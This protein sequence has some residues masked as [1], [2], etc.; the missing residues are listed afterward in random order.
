MQRACVRAAASGWC[1]RLP[2][3]V[4][5]LL[6]SLA[7]ARA[8]EGA[9][10]AA[11]PQPSASNTSS[12]EEIIVVARRREERAQDTP[13]AVS[14]RSGEQLREANAVLLEDIDRDI[15]NVRMVSSPQ[16]VSALDVTIRGQTVN[17]SA[18]VFD[19]AV[20]LYVDGVYVANGQ[21]AM[22]TL[23]DID[24]VEVLRGSQGTLFGRNNTGGSILLLTHRP[25]LQQFSGELAASGGNY[26]EFMDR[27]IVNLPIGSDAAV[28]LAFQGD[29]RQGFGSSVSSGQENFQNQHRYQA[30][31][32]ALWKPGES[33]EL[34]FTYERFEANEVGALL[35]PLSGPAPGTL[36]AQI[37][38]LFAQFPIPG[39]P[40]VS[41]PSDPYQTDGNFHAF[42]DA[43]TD[44]LQL[45]AVQKLGGDLALKLILGYRH[46]DASTALDVDATTLP[47]ADTT[48]Y[49]TSNQ[50]SAEWQIND[51]A[52][53]Q[54]LDW[55]AGLY[56]FRDNGGSPSVQ[57]PASPE[58][59]SALEQL[60]MA[61]GGAVDL[62]PLFPPLPVY[63]QN[64]VTNSS[65]AGYL[66]GEYQLTSDWAVAAGARHT[67]DRREL[68]E[69]AYV[70]IPG[71]GQNCTFLD[72]SLPPPYQINGP[73]PPI[74]KVA[75]FSYWSWEFTTRYR[76]TP[77]LN[78]YLRVGR[79]QRSGGWNSPLATVQD[80]PFR[81]EQLTDGELGL[82][83]DLLGG[84]LAI[85]ADVFYG[86][87]D[88]MQRLLARLNADGTPVTLIT[89]AAQARIGGA[90]LEALWRATSRLS[91]LTSLGWTDARYETFLYQP[92]PGA[93]AQDLSNNEFYQTPRLQGDIG[94]SYQVPLEAG[95]LLLRA[96]YMWQDKIEFNVINDFNYQRAY[97]T[98]NARIA[99]ASHSRSWELA[100][101][102]NNFTDKRYAYTG[103]TLGAPGSPSPTIA[104]QIPGPRRTAGV[105]GT[106]RWAAAK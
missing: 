7:P 95:D 12:L 39:L 90:E 74:D 23:L 46:L 87:Y 31:F 9:P 47:L 27:A 24:S 49:N 93:P 81:P 32:G 5:T 36:V 60:N 78:T 59:L 61:T 77:E 29:S 65:Y 101:F 96:D 2:V 79:S 30:R 42:D 75:K 13:L 51:K 3:A 19:P 84:A 64:W 34:Y 91:L 98:A 22:M 18:I 20:G 54:R 43:K 4:L 57:S 38:T 94:G 73:C 21:G 28:R 53:D 11:A 80:Q 102:A 26:G 70:D 71:F 8:E 50:K 17:R 55:V 69:N 72:T 35:H 52:F 45:T 63:D 62:T 1:V 97:G 88:D 41:F 89:N 92:I 86:K 85:N 68:K 48:L 37:G 33:T 66:H 99:F 103:G 10:A 14:V 82:K 83:A 6:I 104:W 58:F 105:E 25:E 76:L 56:W 40:T 106:W 15:P 44:S 16:S 100:V 67:N